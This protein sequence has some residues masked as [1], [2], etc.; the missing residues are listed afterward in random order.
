VIDKRKE[1]MGLGCLLSMKLFKTS[2][3]SYY[4]Y[5]Y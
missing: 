2:N 3:Y 5:C 4:Y 1:I